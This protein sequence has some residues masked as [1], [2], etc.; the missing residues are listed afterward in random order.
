ME[1]PEVSP[2]YLYANSPDEGIDLVSYDENFDVDEVVK[3]S[4]KGG[5]I[6]DDGV[7][8]FEDDE[9]IQFEVAAEDYTVTLTPSSGTLTDEDTCE[10]PT[11]KVVATDDPDTPLEVDTDYSVA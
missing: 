3:G 2:Q 10:A 6:N 8:V 7:F 11:I 4:T 9:T 1:E 5:S